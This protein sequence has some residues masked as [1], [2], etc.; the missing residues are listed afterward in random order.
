MKQS[1]TLLVVGLV[2]CLSLSVGTDSS[3][4]R[5]AIPA[6]PKLDLAGEWQASEFGTQTLSLRSDGSADLKMQLSTMAAVLYGRTVMLQLAWKLEGNV[7]TQQV[8]G[9]TPAKSV[10]KLTQK[11]GTIQS[12]RVLDMSN[13]KLTVEEVSTGKT[14]S[15]S[16]LQSPAQSN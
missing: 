1:R 6:A 4:S 3:E 12:Y 2:F 8:I 9:G 13:G 7:L 14:S 11:Y 5:A 16:M 10:Q 15:W